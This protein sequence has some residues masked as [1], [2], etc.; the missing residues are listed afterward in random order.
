MKAFITYENMKSVVKAVGENNKALKMKIIEMEKEIV[1]IKTISNEEIASARE[2]NKN[3]EETLTKVKEQNKK[4]KAYALEQKNI[5]KKENEQKKIQAEENQKILQEMESLTLNLKE[6]EIQIE[7]KNEENRALEFQKGDLA[8]K[9]DY[10]KEYEQKFLSLEKEIKPLK[11]QIKY[12]QAEI[13]ESLKQWDI[14]TDEAQIRYN[15]HIA[16]IQK[17]NQDL[18]NCNNDKAN[19]K[20]AFKIFKRTKEKEMYQTCKKKREEK[21]HEIEKL[22]NDLEGWKW[23]L[24][25]SSGV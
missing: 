5:A 22:E 11:A 20:D 9:L 6:R 13:K 23:E 24:I 8:Y 18:Q 16:D 15:K 3:L 14:R 2:A 10:V 7:K 17:L 12:L 19:L 25:N 1:H 4:L 21:V